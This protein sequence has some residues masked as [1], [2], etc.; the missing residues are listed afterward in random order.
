M[1]SPFYLAWRTDMGVLDIPIVPANV[2]SMSSAAMKSAS[3]SGRVM[4]MRSS[5]AK[6]WTSIFGHGLDGK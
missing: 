5:G 3:V 4:S 2:L 1:Y 6:A